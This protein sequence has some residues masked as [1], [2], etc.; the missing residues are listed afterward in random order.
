MSIPSRDYNWHHVFFPTRARPV[1]YSRAH[2]SF[3][4][5]PMFVVG[6]LLA[7]V[8]P[9]LFCCS[10]PLLS[11]LFGSPSLGR[12]G[13]GVTP[14]PPPDLFVSLA[15]LTTPIRT[16]LTVLTMVDA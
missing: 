16:L 13:E 8:A 6:D 7:L 1:H 5:F 15:F 3:L 11:L 4:P 12:P 9:S 2:F 10:L 14:I